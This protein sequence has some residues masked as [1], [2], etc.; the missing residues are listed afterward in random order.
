[1]LINTYSAPLTTLPRIDS[2][3]AVYIKERIWSKNQRIKKLRG[4]GVELTC[5]A[6][7]EAQAVEWVLSFGGSAEL[8]EPIHLREKLREEIDEMR[9]KYVG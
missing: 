9:S 1:M 3:A 5:L 7:D 4:G 6:A 2:Y 8:L